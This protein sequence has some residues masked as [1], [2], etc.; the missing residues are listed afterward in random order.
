MPDAIGIGIGKAGTGS[1][2]FLDCH[3]NVVFRAYEPDV[4]P[5][6][7]YGNLL[8][9]KTDEAITKARENAYTTRCGKN[10]R[11]SQTELLQTISH[12]IPMAAEDEFL[13]EKTPMYS[14]RRCKK[15]TEESCT[16]I[17]A[18]QMKAINPK[19]K[20]FMFIT[21]PVERIVS[22]LKMIIRLAHERMRPSQPKDPVLDRTLREH[23][24]EINKLAVK[25][26]NTTDSSL[27][28]TYIMS[29]ENKLQDSESK[30][31]D[32]LL[33]SGLDRSNNWAEEKANI[34]NQITYYS[35]LD[36]GNYY[37]V[38]QDFDSVLGRDQ[39]HVVDGQAVKKSLNSEFDLLLEF[40]GVPT[41]LMKFKL[42]DQK[43]FYCLEKP[44]MY[45]LGENKG[46]T[47]KYKSFYDAFPELHI[48]QKAYS[49]EMYSTFGF[50]FNCD[51][52]QECC[53]VQTQRFSWLQNYFC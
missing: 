47:Q 25:M 28:D 18:Q 12:S 27:I 21:D 31:K 29:L 11:F 13:I 35:L 49:N 50:I 53:S 26:Q 52:K 14:D 34:Q 16:L 2:A 15:K 17:R 33:L 32:I 24:A 22:H 43:G 6:N 3:P 40:F 36:K 45:C 5:M 9:F 30:L 44:V 48:L 1:L 4:Y 20:I 8:K 38:L 19:V 39:V 42:D 46:V 10:S 37:S 51:S 7:E 23:L 41:G